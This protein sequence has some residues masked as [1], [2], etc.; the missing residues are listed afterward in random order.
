M[1]F[2]PHL[3][4]LSHLS[5]S[6]YDDIE[7]DKLPDAVR[8]NVESGLHQEMKANEEELD[9]EAELNRNL[10]MIQKILPNANL[11]TKSK[12]MLKKYNTI[13]RFDPRSQYND[14]LKDKSHLKT[15]K[16]KEKKDR[17][18]KHEMMIKR[19]IDKRKR[20]IMNANLLLGKSLGTLKEKK[21]VKKN[22]KWNKW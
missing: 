7:E 12:P 1:C 9:Y 6:F 17:K 2:N 16:A 11:R 21:E 20:K 18:K 4:S 3:T 8:L 15:I 14:N 10:D 13:K 19:G 5:Y 22:I